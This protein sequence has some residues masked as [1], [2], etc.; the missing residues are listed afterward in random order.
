MTENN[1]W[2][3]YI[4]KQIVVSPASPNRYLFSIASASVAQAM[5]RRGGRKIPRVKIQGSPL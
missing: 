3:H 4:H 1:N 5:Y 2:T